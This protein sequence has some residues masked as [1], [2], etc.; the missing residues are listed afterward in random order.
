MFVL[1]LGGAFAVILAVYLIIAPIKVLC[2][3]VEYIYRYKLTKLY[4]SHPGLRDKVANEI[5][6]ETPIY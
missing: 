5:R 1:L 3:I 2:T 6:N 4:R